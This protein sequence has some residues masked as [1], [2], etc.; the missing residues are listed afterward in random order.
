MPNIYEITG[1]IR[2]LWDLME[3]GEL[4]DDMIFDAMMNS[5]EELAIKLEGYC[6]WIKNMESDIEGLKKEEDRLYARRKSLENA[7][8]RAKQAMQMAMNEAGEKKMKC[9]T[10]K[11]GLQRNQP[12]VQVDEQYIENIPSKYLVPQEPKINRKLMLEDL[13]NGED[14]SGVAHLVEGESLRIR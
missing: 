11:V 12:S 8:T 4:D 14:L 13:K 1:D 7:I 3:E 5:Q 6:K 9:G 2:K 10:F